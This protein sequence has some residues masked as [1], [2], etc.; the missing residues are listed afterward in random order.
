MAKV[1]QRIEGAVRYVHCQQFFARG[2]CS[3]YFEVQQEARQEGGS[4]V[5]G[6]DM[7]TLWDQISCQA[8]SN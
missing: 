8:A 2:H 1:R 5:S 4:E 6:G 3:Q 7:Q